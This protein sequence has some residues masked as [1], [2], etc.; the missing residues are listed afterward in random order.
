MILAVILVMNTLCV[1]WEGGHAIVNQSRGSR[2]ARF[3][4][5]WR[6][7]G[8]N[9]SKSKTLGLGQGFQNVFRW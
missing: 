6:M 4:S 8:K 1:K 3:A 9:L 2:C 7:K 5:K